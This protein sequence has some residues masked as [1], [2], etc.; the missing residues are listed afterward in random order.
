MQHGIKVWPV[1][2]GIVVDC[3]IVVDLGNVVDHVIVD[4][5]SLRRMKILSLL[6]R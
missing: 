5:R 4:I 6:S 1:C 2:S 3:G